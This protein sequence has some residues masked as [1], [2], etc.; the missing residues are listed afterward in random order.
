MCFFMIEI[1]KSETPF[2]RNDS[3]KKKRVAMLLKRFQIIEIK[4]PL[5]LSKSKAF[6]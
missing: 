3:L 1:L 4:K 2:S 6:Q 5:T